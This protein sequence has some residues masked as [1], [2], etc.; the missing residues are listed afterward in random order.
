MKR[1]SLPRISLVVASICLANCASS[2][3]PPSL[4]PTHLSFW[5]TDV[6]DGP[7]SVTIKLAE[8]RAYFYKGGILAGLSPISSGRE[9][10][11]TITGSF[12]IQEKDVDHRSSLF[13]AYVNDAGEV[14]QSDVNTRKDPKPPGAQYVGASMPCWM[15]IQ[16]GT[17]MH[18]GELPGYPASHGCI[19]LPQHMAEAFYHAVSLGT[20]VTVEP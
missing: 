13:G 10:L 6:P 17:G 8:Q 4:D 12:K 11:D 9:G 20:P 5:K 3:R 18:A 7:P 19:R 15:R 1:P 2:S 16:G 14:I